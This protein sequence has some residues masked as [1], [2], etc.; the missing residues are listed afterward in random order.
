MYLIEKVKEEEFQKDLV[1]C[2]HGDIVSAQTGHHYR[3]K[4]HSRWQS[5]TSQCKPIKRRPFLEP[6]TGLT[7]SIG[8]EL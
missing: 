3:V 6:A 1:R 5:I 8:L 7:F 2:Q 4:K